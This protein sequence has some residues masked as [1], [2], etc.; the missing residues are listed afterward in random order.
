SLRLSSDFL[1][2]LGFGVDIYD[3]VFL[4]DTINRTTLPADRFPFAIGDELMS[5]D[6][7]DVQ[8][9]TDRL[10]KYFPQGN[11]R[12][13]RRQ[14]AQRLTSRSQVRVPHAPDVPDSSTIVI[15]RQSGDVETYT[16]PW[17]K[18]GT[19]ME[20]GPVPSPKSSGRTAAARPYPLE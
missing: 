12:A 2:Q 5:I 7:E 18:T 20:V 3:G 4:I 15:R 19:P 14:G 6:G 13:S 8:S 9:I 16:I 11:P 10:A 17:L 1:A